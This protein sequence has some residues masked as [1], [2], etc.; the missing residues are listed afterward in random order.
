MCLLGGLTPLATIE[1]PTLLPSQ[2]PKTQADII[3]Y[4]KESCSMFPDWQDS[5]EAYVTLYGPIAINMLVTY[6]Q[7]QTV[8]SELGYCPPLSLA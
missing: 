6:L 3:E 2:N 5:C 7:P 8:C 1:T 4:A